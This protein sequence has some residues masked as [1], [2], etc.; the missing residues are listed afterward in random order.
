MGQ[1][2]SREQIT[3]AKEIS[4]E[5]YILS[6][7]ANNVKRIGR[8]YY[9]KDHDSLRISNGLWKWESRGIGGKN[10]IDFLIHVRGYCFVDAVRHLAGDEVA[11]IRSVTPKARPPTEHSKAER[12]PFKLPPRNADNSRVIAYLEKRGIGKAL[13]QE[14]IDRGLLYESATWHNA[15]F[16]GRDE[17][18]KAHFAALRGTMGDFKCDV[19]GSDKS[20][21]FCLPPN[22]RDCKTAIVFES[23]VDALSHKMLCPMV[24]GYRLSLGGTALA[25]L[26]RFL[27]HHAE[28]ENITVCSDNDKAGNSVAAKIAELPGL[29]IIRSLPPAG[30][31]WNEALQANPARE[32]GTS[33]NRNE[34]KELEDKRK[35]ILFLEEPFKYPESFRIK[36]GDSVKVTYA[37]DG[38]VATLK[39]RF[40]DETHLTIGNNT[41]HISELAERMKKNGNKVEPIPNQKPMLNILAA[42][43]GEPLQAVEIP[44]TDAAIKKLVGG[45]FET[46]VLY[47]DGQGINGRYGPQAHDAILRGKEGIAVCGVGGENNTPTS[48]H[49]YWAQKYKRE[50]GTIDPPPEKADFLGKIDKLK[51]KAAAQSTPPATPDRSRK[52]DATELG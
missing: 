12:A 20:Y 28:I 31:D 44:M 8:A 34:V 18:G 37:Y 30:K 45:K 52:H 14:C 41:Y 49:P 7:E 38:E 13:T 1:G 39:C 4:I 10:V 33:I 11:V 15:V 24:D 5:D 50:L 6:H 36:D 17:N 9:L 40:I 35:D 16:V 48:L 26:T 27:E 25:A 19:D 32:A 2:V 46:E 29:C 42:K 51:E 47:V 3:R 43:Y 23:P 22:D 21:G